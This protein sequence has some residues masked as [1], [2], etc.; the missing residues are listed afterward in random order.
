MKGTVL[1]VCCLVSNTFV[2]TRW[3]SFIKLIKSFL[4][5]CMWASD[6]DSSVMLEIHLNTKG[7]AARKEMSLGKKMLLN[8][9]AKGCH[10][11]GVLNVYHCKELDFLYK[12]KHLLFREI[13]LWFH[14]SDPLSVETSRPSLIEDCAALMECLRHKLN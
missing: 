1:R 5:V 12:G 7:Q 10:T 14:F 3:F 6:V 9:S 8:K 13:K 11:N 4:P 2:C